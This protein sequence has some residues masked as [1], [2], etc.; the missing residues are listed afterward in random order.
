MCI[1]VFVAARKPEVQTAAYT[2]LKEKLHLTGLIK[3]I[4]PEKNRYIYFILYSFEQCCGSGSADLFREMT[5]PDPTLNR[6]KINFF[7]NFQKK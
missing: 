1:G 7:L 3:D 2:L 6:V 5:D 4:H